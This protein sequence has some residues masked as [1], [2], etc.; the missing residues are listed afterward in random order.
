VEEGDMKTLAATILA[1]TVLVTARPAPA[2]VV[3]VA[4][5]I[6]A[7]SLTDDTD[8]KAAV[9]SAV[10]DVLQNAIALVPTFVSVENA[11]V[12]GDRLYILIVVGDG[13]GEATMRA[14]S[15]GDGPGM[16]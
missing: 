1:L 7:R 2:Y 5:S 12:V 9:R 10:E 6:P 8:L 15:G 11:R 16:D 13:D 4:T 14:L 3:T